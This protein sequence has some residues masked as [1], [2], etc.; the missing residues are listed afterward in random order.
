MIGCGGVSSWQD[1]IEYM[2]A[3]ASAVQ[4]GSVLGSYGPKIFNRITKD[5]KNYVEK[6]GLKNIREIIGIAHKY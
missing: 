2:M 5:L 6:K 3:G 1:V 4:M